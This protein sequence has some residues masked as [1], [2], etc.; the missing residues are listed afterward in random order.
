MKSLPSQVLNKSFLAHINEE[1]RHSL[2]LKSFAQKLAKKSLSYETKEMIAGSSASDYFQEVDHYSL[3]FAFS[4][5]V[6]NYLYTTY[7]VEQRA[8]VFY[9]VYNEILQKKYFSFS[10]RAIL[11]DEEQHLKEV[12]EKIK[13]LDPFWEPHIDEI[14]EFE[15][16]KYFSLL[17][18]FEKALFYPDFLP[19][20]FPRPSSVTAT[21]NLL[22]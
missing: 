2:L 18:E 14:T 8:L 17:I 13:T 4:N 5:P 22:V 20:S 12:E 7:A 11:K 1:T 9:S 15:H 21:K 6:L 3:K 10:L 19:S 16:Q